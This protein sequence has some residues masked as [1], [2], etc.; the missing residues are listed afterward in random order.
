[1]TTAKRGQAKE[2]GKASGVKKSPPGSA[3]RRERERKSGAHKGKGS[4]G[5]AIPKIG[6]K[7][8]GSGKRGGQLH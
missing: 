3:T 8:I 5:D 1:M 6:K 4:S 7:E 2:T